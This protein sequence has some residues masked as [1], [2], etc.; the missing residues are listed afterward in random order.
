MKSTQP[1]KATRPIRKNTPAAAAASE[2]P[3]DVFVE[4]TAETVTDGMIQAM[5][6]YARRHGD[7]DTA[8]MCCK[9]LRPLVTIT[10]TVDAAAR[11]AARKGC[12]RQINERARSW[13]DRGYSEY[14]LYASLV[15]LGPDTRRKAKRLRSRA[16]SR[17]LCWECNGH[18]G[19]D[20]ERQI[21]KLRDRGQVSVHL[22]CANSIDE[23][24][25]DD[26][27]LRVVAEAA[28]LE[29]QPPRPDESLFGGPWGCLEDTIE[30]PE[31][32]DP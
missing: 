15:G 17:A 13:L 19:P 23:A 14:R 7:P 28:A 24:E 29:P 18:I 12:A 25:L 22:Q 6:N 4:L 11:H 8:V 31:G 21:V 26:S 9:A 27:A 5:L 10:K 2:L 32:G 20:E 1:T 16:D 30:S 3:R